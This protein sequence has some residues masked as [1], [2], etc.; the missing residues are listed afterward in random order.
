MDN[1]IDVIER[2]DTCQLCDIPKGQQYLCN[3]GV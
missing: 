2:N 1:E 3:M